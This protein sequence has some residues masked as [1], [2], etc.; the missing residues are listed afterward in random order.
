[1]MMKYGFIEMD[2]F[3]I[4][5]FVASSKLNDLSQNAFNVLKSCTFTFLYL[6]R[7]ILSSGSFSFFYFPL[8]RPKFTHF[9]HGRGVKRIMFMGIHVVARLLQRSCMSCNEQC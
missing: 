6:K 1:M 8:K 3:Y 5:A 2:P 7:K 4:A 9:T